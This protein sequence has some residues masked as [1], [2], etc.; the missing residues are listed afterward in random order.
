MHFFK[1]I[2]NKLKNI[3]KKEK[4]E[5]NVELEIED[6]LSEIFPGDVIWAR[7]Y[8]DEKEKEEIPLGHREGP[9]I[10]VGKKNNN[11]VCIGGTSSEPMDLSLYFKL[12]CKNHS[13][14]RDGYYRLRNLKIVTK[15]EFIEK[16]DIL[17]KQEYEKIIEGIKI[18][19]TN[20]L[21]FEIPLRIGDVVEK[22]NIY[23]LILEVNDKIST[24]QLKTKSLKME[25][26]DYI[27]Y[28][29]IKQFNKNELKYVKIIDKRILINILKRYKEYLDSKQSKMQRGSVILY[30]NKYYY[31]YGE[32]GENWLAFKILKN[33]KNK[34]SDKI[35]IKGKS[36][37][38]EFETIKLNKKDDFNVVFMCSETEINYIK[39]RRINYKKNIKQQEELKRLNSFKPGVF[40]NNKN[41]NKKRYIIIEIHKKTL[42]C[43]EINKLK[44]GIYN[45]LLIRKE[46]AILSTNTSIE[47]IKWLEKNPKFNLSR[48]SEK[49]DEI[50]DMQKKF[51]SNEYKFLLD[52]M[53]DNQ[54]ITLTKE[55]YEKSQPNIFPQRGSVIYKDN[56]YY[57]IY[58]E[59][60]QNFNAFKLENEFKDNYDKIIINNCE[61][62][63]LYKDKVINKK[64]DFIVIVNATEEEINNIKLQKKSY[65][66][67]NS[68]KLQ[69]DNN[70]K[71]ISE[72]IKIKIGDSVRLNDFNDDNYVVKYTIGDMICCY[73]TVEKNRCEKKY[74][75][76]NI[77]EVVLVNDKKVK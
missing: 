70:K 52:E 73:S 7:R 76:F 64:D 45:P 42:E 26:I 19:N 21:D 27:D 51:L 66:K 20:L 25:N 1:L 11:L 47:G 24:L 40:I 15:K 49:I 60:G 71:I 9:F 23:Y 2:Y 3:L 72:P 17:N 30:K 13:L 46:D 55:E 50:I 58:G 16:L 32:E 36:Y 53:L 62:Y 5:E 67:Q 29:N 77:N 18:N 22:D 48:I 39:K 59:E 8:H 34:D 14:S 4:I 56:E 35:I 10:V 41:Y 6:I 38:T 37:H 43:L 31:I 12:D 54:K 44:K 57:Y 65:K 74:Y 28:S 33:T 68:F 61:Y 63:T 75:Y 69:K